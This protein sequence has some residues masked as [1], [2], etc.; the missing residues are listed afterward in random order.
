[1][2]LRARSG[3]SGRGS[4]NKLI[5]IPTPTNRT[6]ATITAIQS[7]SGEENIRDCR[8]RRSLDEASESGDR[9]ESFIVPATASPAEHL[10][11]L[12]AEIA[13]QLNSDPLEV[14]R[15]HGAALIGSRRP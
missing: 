12:H 5:K 9:P 15:L 4:G 8:E 6:T 10:A 2:G 3:T 13:L 11:Y 7:Q 1:M 14:L